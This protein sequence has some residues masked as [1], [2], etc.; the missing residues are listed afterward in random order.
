[1]SYS[2][3]LYAVEDGILT[4][5]LNR[6]EKLNAF[7]AVMGKEL[8]D[9]LDRAD[10]D[11]E[12]RVIIMT[13]AGRGFCAG[14]DLSRGRDTFNADKRPDARPSGK[15]RDGGGLVSLR[16]YD[17]KK[18]TIA[19]F[20]GPAVGVGITM[21]LP[22]DVRIASSE[23]RFGFVFSRRGIAM[24][25]CSSWFLPRIV[26]ISQA[27]EWVMTG[28]VFGPEEAL[29]GGLVSSLVAPDQLLAA[30]RALAREVADNTAAVS[31]AFN[32]QM[33]WKMLGADHPMEAHKIDS[34]G[35]RE[36]GQ[37]ADA[38]EGVL[39]FLEKRPGTYPLRPSRDM[40]PVYPWWA[41]REFE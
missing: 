9:A 24:E 40:P 16:I 29:A 38:R 11:D 18:P 30:A 36:L 35:M 34:R 15:R 17:L 23:A 10:A 6:P 7:T 33:M 21:A 37:T 20:N 26:G 25:A 39:S 8:L 12:V 19:A 13:G 1:M 32:R 22:M 3:I 41:E 28:R 2:D 27:M 14:A 4:L 5:T 31:V